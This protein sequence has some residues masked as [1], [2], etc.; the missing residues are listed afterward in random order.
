[1]RNASGL[2][3]TQI[4]NWYVGFTR[5][6]FCESTDNSKELSFAKIFLI[7]ANINK[8]ETIQHAV[9]SDC[10]NEVKLAQDNIRY[11]NKMKI[12]MKISA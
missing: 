7:F 2:L 10:S 12:A 3:Y 5:T 11:K 8:V 6:F 4:N 1:M 9:V